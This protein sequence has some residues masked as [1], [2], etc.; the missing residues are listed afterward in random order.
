MLVL[1]FCSNVSLL[2][3]GLLVLGF[4]VLNSSDFMTGVWCFRVL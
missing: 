4:L 1:G 3:S 2:I